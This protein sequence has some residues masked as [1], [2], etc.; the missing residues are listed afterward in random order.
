MTF[1]AKFETLNVMNIKKL[2]VSLVLCFAVAFLGSLVT[3]PSID[4]WYATL[5]KPSF[6][7][8]NWI[9]GPVWTVLYFLMGVSLYMVWNQAKGKKSKKAIQVFLVQLAL[10][11]L[12]SVAFFG[13]HAPTVAFITI[14]ILWGTILYTILLFYKLSK[15]AAYLLIPYLLWVS[16][17]TILN[18]AIVVLNS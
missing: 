2:I 9:F 11:F 7:P 17:A 15:P 18:L 6:N 13:F 12:W 4:S 3:T 10:N 1:E 14:V 16:F 8:P 5:Q